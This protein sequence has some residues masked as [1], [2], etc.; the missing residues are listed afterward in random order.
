MSRCARLLRVTIDPS[1]ILI[2]IMRRI[3][4]FWPSALVVAAVSLPCAAQSG[5]TP[6]P[7]ALAPARQLNFDATVAGL[8]AG[9]AVRSS[10]RTSVGFAIGV[11]GNWLNYMALGGR[12]FAE[13]EGLS[14][15]GKDGADGK[16]LF[17]LLRATVFVRRYFDHGRDIQ[18]G[19]KASGFLHSDSSDDDPGGGGFVGLNVTGM[20][21]QWRY[22]QLG[23]EIDTGLYTEGRPEFGINVAP[24][25]LRLNVR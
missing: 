19:L 13:S 6:S 7:S 4:F 5:A 25:L 10:D 22:L 15:E 17:E 1:S 14:Y 9:F 23:S 3:R 11:G 21:W 2:S 12:H 20:W 18:L 16:E 8:N 24:V